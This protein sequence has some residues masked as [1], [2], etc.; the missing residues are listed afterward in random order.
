MRKIE[1]KTEK[2]KK[3][4]R[5]QFIVGGILILIMVLSTLGYSIGSNMS[6]TGKNQVITY[7]GFEF[8]EQ[9]GFW[10]SKYGNIDLLFKYNPKQTENIT[11][12]LNSINQYGGKPLYIFSDSYEAELEVYRNMQYVAQRMQPACLEVENVTWTSLEESIAKNITEKECK[13]DSPSKNCEDN[14][15][16]II[17]GTEPKIIKK[18]NCVFVIAQKEN[19][20][21]MTDSA[22]FKIFG[23]K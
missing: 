4:R 8:S 2:E 9:N 7:N 10:L 13:K 18:E 1:T 6:D 12:N 21:M 14:F 3:N 11:Q 17:E 15:I 16:I 20:T 5:N 23:I 22:L 19:L